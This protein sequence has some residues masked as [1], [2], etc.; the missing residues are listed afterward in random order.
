MLADR[1]WEHVR[2]REHD[3]VPD[4][5]QFPRCLGWHSTHP[6]RHGR[7]G[8]YELW[9]TVQLLSGRVPDIFFRELDYGVV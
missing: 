7:D 9:T 8:H 3:L 5:H 1:L 6:R 4:A 2:S